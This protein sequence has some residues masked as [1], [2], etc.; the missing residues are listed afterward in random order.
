[1]SYRMWQL[2]RL[3]DWLGAEGLGPGELTVERADEFVAVDRAS[4][5]S[6][7]K[8]PRTLA[9]PLEYLREAAVVRPAISVRGPVDE[10]LDGFGGYLSGERGLAEKS[11]SE[12]R[13]VVRPFVAAHEHAGRIA[14]E[15]LTAGDVTSF[16][17]RECPRLSVSESRQLTKGLRALL[18]YLH[19]AG[20]V[21]A[22]LGWAV[23]DVAD[24]RCQALPRGL[25][26]AA[27]AALLASC[28]RSRT[29]GLR[30]YAILVV[31]ARLGLRAAEV[32][33]MQLEDL[34][35]HAGEVLVRG[36]GRRNERLPLPVDVGEA[37]AEYLQRRPQAASRA[38]FLRQ[39]APRSSLTAP[40]VSGIVR[41]ACARAGLPLV[42][43]HRLRHTAATEMLRAG[44]SLSEVAQVLRHRSLQTTAIYA[45]VDHR[46]LRELAK[47]WP[48]SLA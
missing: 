24:L 16:L 47:P 25:E 31:L 33:A 44:G 9:L 12:Y 6:H 17:A 43:A 39:T 36:K 20:L 26:P 45:K 28:D 41:A 5:V 27:V 3:S 48:G 34:D 14:V 32:G 35:W 1:M 37:L 7:R 4:S 30:D 19:V 23:P 10:L 42:C 13:R 8:S 46:R 40:A 38:V 15:R 21:E 11:V 18:R 2:D 22:R 29:V